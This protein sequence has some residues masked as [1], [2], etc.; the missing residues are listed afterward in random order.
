[1]TLDELLLLADEYAAADMHLNGRDSSKAR[2]T[3]AA[4]LREVLK[5]RPNLNLGREPA[6]PVAWGWIGG[7]GRIRDCIAPDTHAVLEGDYTVPLYAA[8]FVSRGE[9]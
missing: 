2:A 8:P 7:D 4:A 1:M 9:K 6:E 3:L 5:E